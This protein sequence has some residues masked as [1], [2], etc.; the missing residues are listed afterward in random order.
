MRSMQAAAIAALFLLILAS[1]CTGVDEQDRY[2]EKAVYTNEYGLSFHPAYP[3]LVGERTMLKLRPFKPA[4]KVTLYTDRYQEIPMTYRD[5]SWWG[6]FL[7]PEDYSEGGHFFIVWIRYP[8]PPPP[9]P[10]GW[11]DALQERL[12]IKKSFEVFWSKSVVTY[13]ATGEGVPLQEVFEPIIIPLPPEI[14]LEAEEEIVPWVGEGVIEGL[15]LSPEASPL[16]I[17][18]SQTITFKTRSLEG[19]KEGYAPGTL[20]TR[21]ETLRV[22]VSGRAADTDIEANLYRTSATGVT[23]I[24]EREEKIS[25]LL[26][27][28]STEAYLGDFTADLTET[29]FTR[30]DKVLSGGRLRGDY[31]GW[32]FSALYSSPRGEAKYYRA[33]G[34]GTQ[35]P[36]QLDFSPV[37]IDSERV[38]VDGFP[39]KRG[40]DYRIDYQAG[41]VTFIKKVIDR[42][43][44]IQVY[45]DHRQTAYQHLTYGL[46]AFIRPSSN[47]KIG[48]T[49]LDDSDGLAGAAQI[50]QSMSQEAVD[51]RG[52]YVAGV[53]GSFVSDNL[54]ANGE[55]AYSDRKLDLLSPSATRETGRAGK[56]HIA[57]VYGPFGISGHIKRVGPKFVPVAAADP[58]QD[59]WECG[60]SLSYRPGAF[61][62]SKGGYDHQKYTRSGV[63][64]ENTFKSAR[65]RLSP[66]GLPSLEY[67]FS[68]TDES[69]DP[70]T[71]SPIRRV[72]TRNSAETIHRFGIFSSSLKGT[73]EKW[74]QKSP[75]QEVTD[76]RKVNL[77]LATAGT[78]KF[79]FSSNVELED[80]REPDGSEPFRKTY[81][82]MVSATPAQKYFV[83]T[84]LQLIEDSVQGDTNV[85]DLSYRAEPFPAFKTDGKYTIA[86]VKEEFPV[87]PE[88]VSKQ[89]GSFSFELRPA[90]ALRLRYLYKPNFTRLLRTDSLSY[91][92]EQQQWEANLAL[93]QHALLGLIY[94]LNRS[95][96]IY[97]N[98][99]PDFSA[100]QS[101]SDLDSI[102]YT[103]KL[104]PFRI[105]STELNYLTE[106][107]SSL[108]LSSS[109]EPYLYTPG[110]GRTDKFD[111]AV[112]TSLSE[113]FSVDS[114]YTFQKTDQGTGES[115]SNLNNIKAHTASLKGIWNYDDSWTFSLSGSYARLSDHLLSQVTYTIAPGFG[116]IYRMGDVLRVDLD[117]TYS[118]SYSGQET[119]KNIYSVKTRYA[120]SDYVNLTVRADQEVSRA[121]DYRLTD[122][123]GNV[124]ITL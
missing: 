101:S 46:R 13:R 55:I 37:V 86:S 61:F 66:E 96:S 16:L 77:G 41:T 99:Y 112:K 29:E 82:L 72:I 103:L 81:D 28:G 60:A 22:N 57:S 44:V 21:E 90:R 94:R 27:R 119:E 31:G 42:N 88:A 117:Y 110:S 3:P 6:E 124:E 116:I 4:Q 15:V 95:F 45:Y 69:N 97:K 65:A 106:S 67:D 11:F 89:A 118:K 12:G 34:D 104:A 79:A 122:I 62:G 19:S 20:Q 113:Q 18:G 1:Q 80:R 33:Y 39:H 76:Y 26:R 48:A 68:E 121:P 93:A 49:Y 91:Q 84:S 123:T 40:D 70:V 111:L 102:L 108:T 71:G 63:I 92:S 52:H 73:L 58:E 25:I 59:V 2:F 54:S 35:G 38:Y 120:L 8:Y 14:S 75:S 114:R 5:G 51:P 115:R 24:G 85:T 56:L 17:K 10:P 43:S 74:L 87:T 7:M 32:G 98:D 9:E 78:D 64:Y 36:Y 107:A 53:D 109:A 100:R 50:R 47:L 83:S 105:M 30:L 23:Q